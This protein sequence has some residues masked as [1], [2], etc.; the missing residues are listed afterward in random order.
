[1]LT[2]DHESTAKQIGFASGIF[3][4]NRNVQQFEMLE[5]D[6]TEMLLIKMK[7]MGNTDFLISGAALSTLM[8]ETAKVKGKSKELVECFQRA[9]GIVIYRASSDQKA[10]LME[11]MRK[12][13]PNKACLAVGDGLNDVKMLKAATIGVGIVTKEGTI[14]SSSADFSIAHVKD[15]TRLL[16]QHGSNYG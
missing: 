1:M 3:S 8:T 4:E 6:E 12:V 2:G 9:K 13:D 10:N 11:F 14:A 5:E 7:R 16:F 15:L